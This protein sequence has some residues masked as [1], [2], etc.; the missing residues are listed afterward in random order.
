MATCRLQRFVLFQSFV[1]IPNGN[2][3]VIPLVLVPFFFLR[4]VV[5]IGVCLLLFALP[6][7]LVCF[8]ALLH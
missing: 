5:L 4:L 8:L 3:P 2:D 6:H 7:A 1:M